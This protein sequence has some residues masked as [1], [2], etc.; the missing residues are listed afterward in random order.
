LEC[1]HHPTSWESRAGWQ[2]ADILHS[3]PRFFGGWS[4]TSRT[5]YSNMYAE[6]L[7]SE[8]F[9]KLANSHEMKSTI[10]Q[11]WYIVAKVWFSFAT[12]FLK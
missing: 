11:M 10:Q 5:P 6:G 2:D 1:G 9:Y 7:D 12:R 8:S 3:T 4:K